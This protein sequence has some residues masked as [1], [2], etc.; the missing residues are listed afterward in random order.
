MTEIIDNFNEVLLSLVENVASVC[1]RSIIATN[2]NHV[3][4]AITNKNSPN[5]FIELFCLKVLQYRDQIDAGDDNFFMNKDF[6]D[7]LSDQSSSL[8][9]IVSSLKCVWTQLK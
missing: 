4:K 7:D 6:K 9:D 2:I 1:P 5:K 3:R 8:I